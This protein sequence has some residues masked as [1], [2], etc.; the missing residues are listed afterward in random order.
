MLDVLS[1]QKFSDLYAERSALKLSKD[2]TNVMK[3]LTQAMST[4]VLRRASG[5]PAERF[6]KAL[7]GLRLKMR[8]ASIGVKSESRTMHLNV[9]NRTES[10]LASR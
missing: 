5:L 3:S 7:L 2:E 10:W 8:I 4:P 6:G 1:R 9:Y